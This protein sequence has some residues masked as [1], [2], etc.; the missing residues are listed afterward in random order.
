MKITTQKFTQQWHLEICVHYNLATWLFSLYMSILPDCKNTVSN[1]TM[2]RKI[3]Y[4]I[5]DDWVHI[6]TICIRE[7]QFSS[8]KKQN[9]LFWFK[10]NDK[11]ETKLELASSPAAF[12]LQPSPTLLQAIGWINRMVKVEL[13]IQDFEYNIL[14][15]MFRRNIE[16]WSCSF[17]SLIS[18]LI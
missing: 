10:K 8:A 9:W 13:K 2:F 5:S 3:K 12:C 15:G 14:S 17:I 18:W 6:L 11:W 4:F 1:T 7:T 16:L